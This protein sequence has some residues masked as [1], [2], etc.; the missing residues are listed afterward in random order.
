LK[1][2]VTPDGP[3]NDNETVWAKPFSDA[4]Y[5]FKVPDDPC[6]MEMAELESAT[7]KSPLAVCAAAPV[8]D[9]EI[10]AISKVAPTTD[11]TSR[12]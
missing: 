2:A 12:R 8:S 4:T 10:N 7:E 3:V 6:G 1:D 9:K 5:R 11:E